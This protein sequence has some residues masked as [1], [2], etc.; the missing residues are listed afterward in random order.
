MTAALACLIAWSAGVIAAVV[1][2]PEC[3]GAGA[4]ALAGAAVSACLAVAV[5]PAA[6]GL[7]MAAALLGVVRG[8]AVGGDPSAAARAPALAGVQAAVTGIVADD[9][10]LLAA[11]YEVLVQPVRIQTASGTP[12]PAGNVLAWVKSAIEPAPGDQVVV[13]GRLDLPRDQPGFDRRAYL[14][15]Q[16][17]YLEI[18]TAQLSVTG[19]G[20]RIRA[21]PGRLREQYRRAVLTLLPAPHAQILVAIVLGVRSGIPPRL[22]RDLVAT[23]LVHL[24]VLSGLKVAVFAKLARGALER[25]L[26]RLATWPVLALIVVYALAGG[27]TPAAVRAAAMGGLTLAAAHL[28]RPTHVWTSLAATAAAMLAWRPDLA[29][30][31]GFQLSFVGTA[32]IILLTPAIERRLGWMPGWLREPFAVTCAAQVGTAPFMATDFHLLSPV[33]P[34]ANALVLP[35]LPAMVAAGLLMAPLAALP[36]VSSVLALPLTGLVAYLEQVAALLARL[37]AA[38]L[39]APPFTAPVGGAY[40]AVLGAAVAAAKTRGRVRTASLAIGA[41]LP[42][43]VAG[44]E[45]VAWARPAPSVTVLD[46]G[47]GQSVLLAGPEG[48]VL[49]DGGPSPSRLRDELGAHLPPW[50][51]SLAG[52]VITGPGLGHVGGLAQFED[53]AA[54][55][56]LPPGGLPGSAWRTAALAEVTRGALPLTV[57]AGD[58][59]HLAGLE[60]DV[61]SPEPDA[62]DPGQLALRV[63]GPDG[64]T[65]C[66]LADLEPDSQT[67]AAP[68]LA[69]LGGCETMMLP[70]AGTSAP[71]PEMVAAAHASRYVVSDAGAR[72]AR[73]LPTG[74]I[75]KTSEEGA[76]TVPL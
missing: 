31:V 70:S 55:V 65:F 42:L 9:P 18:R 19:A 45:V 34:I 27:A 25:P 59:V 33:A 10:R 8:E 35:L 76:I 39:P 40:Y 74:A 13:T 52:L 47:K 53:A 21:V 29:W 62:V 6:I 64:R 71:V 12:A 1:A 69:A 68:R 41:L 44:A 5:R 14:A 16:G 36:E 73:D 48:Y 58:R 7:A 4:V 54:T 61:L 75:L 66:D 46:V 11:G 17:A 56:V 63:R 51:R 50:Q 20:P 30:D 28:G 23:G 43:V 2:V 60:I 22:E 15:Q 3:P 57:H 32:A 49:V 24:L 26:G 38:A 67:V 37:P 72:T